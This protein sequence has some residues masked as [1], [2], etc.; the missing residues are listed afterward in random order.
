MKSKRICIFLI[1]LLLLITG[2]STNVVNE[3]E[4]I[5]NEFPPSMIGLI[6]INGIEHPIEKGA[7]KWERKIGSETESVQT[8]HASPNQMADHI[9]SISVKPNEKIDI[10]IEES[11]EIIVYLWN[12]KG[13]V[14]EVEQ[15]GNQITAPPSNGKYIYEVLANW[16][17]GTVSYTFVLEIQ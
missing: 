16:T 8:D 2:C 17:N 4:G 11:P 9:E 1:C 3:T 15:Q 5:E 10:K 14:K 6:N 12:E 13:R 7:F